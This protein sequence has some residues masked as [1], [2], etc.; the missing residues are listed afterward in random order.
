MISD[1][2]FDFRC[3]LEIQFLEEFFKSGDRVGRDIFMAQENPMGVFP[4]IVEDHCIDDV[5]QKDGLVYRIPRG[6]CKIFDLGF[7]FF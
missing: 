7:I 1:S 3:K 5:P 4:P 6:L 2:V